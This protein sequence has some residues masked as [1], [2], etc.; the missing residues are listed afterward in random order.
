MHKTTNTQ[1]GKLTIELNLY[2]ILHDEMNGE[3]RQDLIQS[4]S[5][6]D[7][8]IGYVAEQLVEGY[9]YVGFAGSWCSRGSSALQKARLKIAENFDYACKCS[10][11]DLTNRIESL[12]ADNKYLRE[13]RIYR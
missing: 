11:K 9:T 6:A 3:M 12:E 8:V 7:E 4:L 10:I 13:N 1:S 5:C 2:D